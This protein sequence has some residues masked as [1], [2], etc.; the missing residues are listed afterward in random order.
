MPCFLCSTSPRPRGVEN[1]E[2]YIWSE[3]ESMTERIE[4]VNC[5]LVAFLLLD[6]DMEQSS[7][8]RLTSASVQHIRI[9]LANCGALVLVPSGRPVRCFTIELTMFQILIYH[10]RIFDCRQPSCHSKDRDKR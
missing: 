7:A 6:S 8:Q 4:M 5:T 10:D 3:S 2:D 9:Y 1:E